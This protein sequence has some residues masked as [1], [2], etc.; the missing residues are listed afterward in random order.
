MNLEEEM[1]F[2]QNIKGC[3]ILESEI[4]I[5]MDEIKNGQTMDWM[6]YQLY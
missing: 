4:V 3:S 5:S 2:E 6:I 1:E